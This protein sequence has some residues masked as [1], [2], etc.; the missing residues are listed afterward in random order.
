MWLTLLRLHGLHGG[1]SHQS[2]T[3]R[4][5]PPDCLPVNGPPGRQPHRTTIA[6]IHTERGAMP[7]PPLKHY[8]SVKTNARV[9]SSVLQWLLMG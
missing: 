1:C 6:W 5:W 4:H 3:S 7:T 9:R 8:S 2:P